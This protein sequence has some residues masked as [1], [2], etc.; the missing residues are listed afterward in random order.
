MDQVSGHSFASTGYG[1]AYASTGAPSIELAPF[2]LGLTFTIPPT[3]ESASPT[4]YFGSALN[5][6]QSNHFRRHIPRSMSCFISTYSRDFIFGQHC[7]AAS[8]PQIRSACSPQISLAHSNKP[9]S[10]DT[11]AVDIPL[12]FD[13]TSASTFSQP[14]MS[15]DYSRTCTSDLHNSGSARDKRSFNIDAAT[16]ANDTPVSLDTISVS[17]PVSFFDTT[18]VRPHLH[19]GFTFARNNERLYETCNYQ[20]TSLSVD[21]AHRQLTSVSFDTT[22]ASAGH[23]CVCRHNALASHICVLR[24]KSPT[25]HIDMLSISPPYIQLRVDFTLWFQCQ[26]GFTSTSTLNHLS[27]MFRAAL[28]LSFV[29]ELH[30]SI[31]ATRFSRLH[32]LLMSDLVLA[33]CYGSRQRLALNTCKLTQ[34]LVAKSINMCAAD[35]RLGHN[36]NPAL[37]TVCKLALLSCPKSSCLMPSFVQV[38]CTTGHA[39]AGQ[40]SVIPVS[41]DTNKSIASVSLDTTWQLIISVCLAHAVYYGIRTSICCPEWFTDNSALSACDNLASSPDN[42]SD[43]FSLLV[44]ASM[45][46]DTS[47]LCLPGQLNVDLCKP[48]VDLLLSRL[49]LNLLSTFLGNS[50]AIRE[51]SLNTA[52]IPVSFD[53]N[54]ARTC[55]SFDT[56][57]AH[58]CVSFDTI[59]AHTCVSFDTITAHTCVSFDTISA[60]T[61]V[62]FDTATARTSVSRGTASAGTSVSFDTTSALHSSDTSVPLLRSKCDSH[63]HFQHINIYCNNEEDMYYPRDRIDTTPHEQLSVRNIITSLFEPSSLLLTENTAVTTIKTLRAIRLVKICPTGIKCVTNQRP[64]TNVTGILAVSRTRDCTSIVSVSLDTTTIH[65][66]VFDTNSVVTSCL[67]VGATTSMSATTLP[68][69]TPTSDISTVTT[70]ASAGLTPT[71]DT[72]TSM[73]ITSTDTKPISTPA[74]LDTTTFSIPVPLDQQLAAYLCFLTQRLAVYLCPLT[75]QLAAYLCS[76]T[77]RLAVYLC[78]LT[79]Q[80]AV[81]TC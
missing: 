38:Q 11:N 64:S 68:G 33:T 23:I 46:G 31:N 30:S 34:L 69:P 81:Y 60:H 27:T 39:S 36:L 75:R 37:H 65:A 44:S 49:H 22:N 7:C 74:S 53:T 57:S 4:F 54:T 48:A 61:C 17:T 3:I 8:S 79:R 18:S 43:D 20:L 40:L 67:V 10:F 28:C 80:L 32:S 71:S 63:L 19:L 50:T 73:P 52:R 15:V 45:S 72:S 56:I 58:T 2:T 59:S 24:H 55:V 1:P 70:T 6:S 21:T 41:L 51:V 14:H 42:Y 47:C 35:H 5:S 12:S 26:L 16:H 9:V 29:N 13:M 78:P 77:Q 76:L 62:S 66:P 25:V